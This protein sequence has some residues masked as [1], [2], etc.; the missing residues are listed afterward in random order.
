MGIIMAWV[1]GW[2]A[3]GGCSNNDTPRWN[4][5]PIDKMCVCVRASAGHK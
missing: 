1:D 5:W 4:I 3:A 2:V